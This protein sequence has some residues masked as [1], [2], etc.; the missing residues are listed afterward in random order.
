[1]IK[2]RGTTEGGEARDENTKTTDSKEEK[3][4]GKEGLKR[5]KEEWVNVLIVH[6]FLKEWV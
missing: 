2:E 1:M 6:L 3:N 5:Y 4:G